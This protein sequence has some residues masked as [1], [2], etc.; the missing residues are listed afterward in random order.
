MCV[1]VCMNKYVCVCMCECIC[2]C[3]CVCVCVCVNVCVSNCACVHGPTDC[4]LDM[5]KQRNN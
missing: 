1:C 3:I 5:F 2:E 4:V